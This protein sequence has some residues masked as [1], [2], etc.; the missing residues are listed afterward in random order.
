MK[1]AGG[2]VSQLE[3]VAALGS[4]SGQATRHPCLLTLARVNKLASTNSCCCDK[5]SYRSRPYC[6]LLQRPRLHSQ[7]EPKAETSGDGGPAGGGG[8]GTPL[9]LLAEPK[10]K[11]LAPAILGGPLPL[12]PLR[13]LLL[14]AV[15]VVAEQ[16]G[17]LAGL[18]RT[19]MDKTPMGD[20]GGGGRPPEGVKE[21]RR[22]EARG[23]GGSW[24][25]A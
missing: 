10:R 22:G 1:V 2:G 11:A 8:R 18:L 24:A 9:L 6:F 7:G 23:G 21:S 15:V 5:R 14:L 17:Q 20:M 12:L 13:P 3:R 19:A 16:G 4:F 25:A